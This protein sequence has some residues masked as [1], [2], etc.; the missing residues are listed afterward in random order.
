MFNVDCR[1]NCS[2]L[3][4]PLWDI[5]FSNPWPQNHTTGTC[6]HHTI[7]N[8]KLTIFHL[9]KVW[10]KILRPKIQYVQ[11]DFVD[12]QLTT[13]NLSFR[14]KVWYTMF[15]LRKQEHM[16]HTAHLDPERPMQ[17]LHHW[18]SPCHQ[19]YFRHQLLQASLLWPSSLLWV[20]SQTSKLLLRPQRGP[21][22]HGRIGEYVRMWGLGGLC[23]AH[24]LP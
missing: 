8:Q 1:W 20:S 3:S 4:L 12:E 10:L 13:L 9:Y 17:V 11:Y 19:L 24:P 22:N 18:W 5:Q 23:Q 21:G 16:W 6:W 2:K 7:W 14:L 15:L